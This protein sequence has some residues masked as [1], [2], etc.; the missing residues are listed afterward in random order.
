[1]S[2]SQ[3]WW[4]AA[5]T[6]E[7]GPQRML[8]T[9]GSRLAPLFRWLYREWVMTVQVLTE[10]MGIQ[11]LRGR[12]HESGQGFVFQTTGVDYIIDQYEVADGEYQYIISES[13]TRDDSLQNGV[14]VE[15]RPEYPT[16]GH[17]L[18]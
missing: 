4:A 3:D 5:M 15:V 9:R 13:S 18:V 8:S 2:A 16:D 1:M 14:V 10:N 6:A 12:L 7:D 11:E 17:E